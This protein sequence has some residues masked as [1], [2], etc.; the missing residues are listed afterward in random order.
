MSTS[1]VINN[2]DLDIL[3]KKSE[4][5]YKLLI[6]KKAKFSTN[7]LALRGDFYFK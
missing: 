4:N 7:L 6:S 3:H 1:L 5:Y 2:K